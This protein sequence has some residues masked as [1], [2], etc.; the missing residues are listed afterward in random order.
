MK[1]SQILEKWKKFT[2]ETK[3]KECDEE[4]ILDEEEDFQ[5]AVKQGYVKDRDEY[6]ETGPQDPGPAFPEKTKKTRALSAPE[7]YGGA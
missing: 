7:P 4:E 6:L 5:K 1:L 2:T 3:E